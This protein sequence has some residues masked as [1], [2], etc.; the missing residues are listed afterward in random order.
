MRFLTATEARQAPF[1]CGVWSKLIPNASRQ[2]V[3]AGGYVHEKYDGQ[4][5]RDFDSAADA[6]F[7]YE[8]F[9]PQRM[10]AHICTTDGRVAVDATIVQRVVLGPVAVETAVRVIEV[11]RTADRAFFAYVTLRGHPER[12]IASFAVVREG[13][14]IRFQ[15]E[16]WSRAGSWL[17]VIGRPVSRAIQHWITREAVSSFCAARPGVES[18]GVA[19][20]S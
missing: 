20:Q 14:Q 10:V 6:L 11:E 16:A 1:A 12:G 4:I 15:M 5:T 9:A 8:I 18:D 7:G 3:A 19:P 13:V 2:T 17:T